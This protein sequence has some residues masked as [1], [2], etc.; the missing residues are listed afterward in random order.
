MASDMI[1]RS[2]GGLWQFAD[3]ARGKFGNAACA[4][5]A[6]TATHH[7]AC[8]APEPPQGG[9]GKRILERRFDLSF[10]HKLAV[11]DY[12]RAAVV[13]IGSRAVFG[14]IGDRRPLD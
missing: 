13:L 6:L 3:A 2:R 8:A 5:E 7:A 1:P 9:D 10:R 11:T 12:G 4:V 14:E